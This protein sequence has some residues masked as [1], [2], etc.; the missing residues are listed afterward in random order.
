M[1][2]S[3]H[4]VIMSQYIQDRTADANTARAAGEARRAQ[5]RRARPVAKAWKRRVGHD[6]GAPPA[7]ATSSR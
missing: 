4:A 1:D 6:I 5:R 2:S 7:A 3:V